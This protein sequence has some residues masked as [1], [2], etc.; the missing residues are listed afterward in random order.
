M[1]EA[2]SRAQ[3]LNTTNTSAQKFFISNHWIFIKAEQIEF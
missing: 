2:S 1:G 3:K